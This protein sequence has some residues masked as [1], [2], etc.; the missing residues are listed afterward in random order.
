MAAAAELVQRYNCWVVLKGAGSVCAMTDGRRFINT[1]GNPGLSSAGT[2]DILSGMIG[3][4]LAQRLEPENA[5][6][7][8]VY[9]HGAAADALQKQHGGCVG[10]TAS[11]IP[12]AARNL[13]NQ[14]ITVTSAPAPHRE[15]G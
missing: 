2:G 9:L 4:F 13:L 6:L 1:S 11:E 8:A 5:L 15:E 7:A 12:N 10:M 3:A 14:W